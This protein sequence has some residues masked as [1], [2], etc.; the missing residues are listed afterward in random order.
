M[1]GSRLSIQEIKAVS[2]GIRIDDFGIYFPMLSQLRQEAW[3][4]EDL[5]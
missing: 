4:K 3:H 5:A 1:L 2:Q